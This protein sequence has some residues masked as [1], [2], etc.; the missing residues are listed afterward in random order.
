MQSRRALRSVFLSSALAIT[1]VRAACY[2]PRSMMFASPAWG[3]V[4]D[5]AGRRRAFGGAAVLAVVGGVASAFSRS[6][7]WLVA[8]RLVVGSGLVGVLPMYSLMEGA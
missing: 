6:L 1:C 5:V 3:A 7:T 2:C 4:A 8:A